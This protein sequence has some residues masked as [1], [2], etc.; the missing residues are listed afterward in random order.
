MGVEGKGFQ[1]CFALN[2]PNC[3]DSLEKILMLGKIEEEKGM[4][5]DTM[6]GWH[7]RLN[8]REFEQARELVMDTEAWC[9]AVHGEA[10]SRTQLSN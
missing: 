4:T 10:K 2:I 5:E 7:H 9:T 1:F 3:L 6:V 8:G